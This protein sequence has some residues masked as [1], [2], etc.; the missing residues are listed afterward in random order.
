MLDTRWNYE[1]FQQI[2][3]TA[4]R[5]NLDLESVLLDELTRYLEG[6]SGIFA[7]LAEHSGISLQGIIEPETAAPSPEEPPLAELLARADEE[8]MSFLD[9]LALDAEVGRYSLTHALQLAFEFGKYIAHMADQAEAEASSEPA[10]EAWQQQ[11]VVTELL[12]RQYGQS[13]GCSRP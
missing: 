4:R 8:G 12:V 2:A 11:A 3:E 9:S 6:K 13:S 7:T 5:K 1:T 10:A